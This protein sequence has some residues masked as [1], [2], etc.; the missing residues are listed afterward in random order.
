[1]AL[2]PVPPELRPLP[3]AEA[4]GSTHPLGLSGG[5][6][7]NECMKQER[8]PAPGRPPVGARVFHGI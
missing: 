7:E 3:Y 8:E 4:A 1:M 2:G 6:E 5:L